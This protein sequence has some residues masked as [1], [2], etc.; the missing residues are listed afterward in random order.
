M[1]ASLA[2]TPTRQQG[3]GENW[4]PSAQPVQRAEN[5]CVFTTAET[6]REKGF[7]FFFPSATHTA[8]AISITAMWPQREQYICQQDQVLNRPSEP[9]NPSRHPLH[10][11]QQSPRTPQPGHLS[12]IHSGCPTIF[13]KEDISKL[14]KRPKEQRATDTGAHLEAA[15]PKYDTQ[16]YFWTWYWDLYFGKLRDKHPAVFVRNVRVDAEAVPVWFVRFNI[17]CPDSSIYKRHFTEDR[18]GK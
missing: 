1:F 9:L 10:W 5:S 8:P 16:V 2:T 14:S 3:A 17:T 15:A 4:K 7:F 18:Y 11:P 6:Q 13:C 12:P